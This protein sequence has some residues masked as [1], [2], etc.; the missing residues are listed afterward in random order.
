VTTQ[1][2]SRTQAA[3]RIGVTLEGLRHL[4]LPEPDAQIGPISGWLPKTIDTWNASRPNR[5]R[6]P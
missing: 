6:K 3:Q 2:L 1:Y 5:A 4:E